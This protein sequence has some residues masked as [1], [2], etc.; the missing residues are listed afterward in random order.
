MEEQKGQP[1]HR[2][3]SGSPSS[4]QSLMR[5]AHCPEPLEKT[6][7]NPFDPKGCILMGDIL[8]PFPPLPLVSVYLHAARLS[9]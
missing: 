7:K 5:S 9:P 6:V 8:R 3:A 4:V 1:V 2:L